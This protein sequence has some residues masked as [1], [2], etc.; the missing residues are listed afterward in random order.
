MWQVGDKAEIFYSHFEGH[1]RLALP[2]SGSDNI[3]RELARHA[4]VG[5]SG[6][7]SGKGLSSGNSPSTEAAQ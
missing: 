6:W 7:V 5:S 3:E 4:G 2:G 1:D